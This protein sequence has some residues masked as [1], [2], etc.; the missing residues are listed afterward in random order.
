MLSLI[1][2]AF[3]P[4]PPEL[5]RPPAWLAELT[6]TG[7]FEVVVFVA[8]DRDGEVK[9]VAVHTSRGRVE[10]P[11]ERW[12]HVLLDELKMARR[13]VKNPDSLRV[14]ADERWRWQHV[15]EVTKACKEAGFAEIG[16]TPS[17]KR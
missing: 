11:L 15:G 9:R 12:Q 5:D 16:F 6:F 10:V 4:L 1:L 13:D 7:K 2:L 17:P 14:I 8:T 3:T